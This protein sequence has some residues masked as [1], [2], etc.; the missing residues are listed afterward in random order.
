MPRKPRLTPE[1]IADY[2]RG[3]EQIADGIDQVKAG[4]R[5][6]RQGLVGSKPKS[7]K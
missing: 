4:L 2:E 5:Q 3:S 6:I 1:E 7:S